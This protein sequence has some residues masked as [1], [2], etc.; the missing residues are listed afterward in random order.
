MKPIIILFFLVLFGLLVFRYTNSSPPLDT[1]KI[2]KDTLIDYSNDIDIS[3]KVIRNPSTSKEDLLVEYKRLASFYHNGVSDKYIKGKLVRGVEPN[4]K[5]AIEVYKIIGGQLGDLSVLL[6]WASIHHYGIPGF[7]ELEDHK[8]AREIYLH[9][10]YKTDDEYQKQQ[11]KDKLEEMGVVME[12]CSVSSNSKKKKKRTKKPYFP[13]S[14]IKKQPTQQTNTQP[15]IT[16]ANLG[17]NNPNR[18]RTTGIDTIGTTGFRATEE[19][20]VETPQFI[21]IKD[22][23][24]NV[25][26]SVLVK[27]VSKAID[28]LKKNTQI[29]FDKTTSI[30][31]IRTFII[32]TP[33][34]SPDRR[35]N[36]IR[37][38]DRIEMNNDLLTSANTTEVDVLH[39]VWNRIHN[40]VNKDN[41]QALKENL[42]DELSEAVEHGNIVCTTG[43]VNRIIDS[44]NTIDPEISI[45][46]KWALQK[47]MVE[48]A[49]KIL[50]DFLEKLS[51][52]DRGDFESLEPTPEQERKNEVLSGR[53]KEEIRKE[54]RETYVNGGILTDETL[55]AELNQWIDTIV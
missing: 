17:N 45:K 31:D 5:K 4:P 19:K 52:E 36:A 44:I 24:H 34:I 8:K 9:L 23:K 41:E 2:E 53:I 30:R 13:Q 22:D 14:L 46:P 47:E 7:E 50:Q 28:T 16:L 48:K 3:M 55:N 43:R 11:A 1:K 6:D 10:Y 39:L 21:E 35:E 20:E 18:V 25:H 40:D 27:T 29:K 26:D 32:N 12:S 38:L 33:S 49:G 15:V 37:V 51:E 42:V 54:F